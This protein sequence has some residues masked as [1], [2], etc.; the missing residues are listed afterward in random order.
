MP[1]LSFCIETHFMQFL[2]RISVGAKLGL[3]FAAVLLITGALGVLSIVQLGRV[4][5]TASDMADSWMPSM[6]AAQTASLEVARL[7]TREYRFLLTDEAQRPA[8]IEQLKSAAAAVELQLANYARLVQSDDERNQLTRTQEDWAAYLN[9]DRAMQDAMARGD[10]DLASE[11]LLKRGVPS[12]DALLASLNQLTKM[13]ADGAEA[14]NDLGDRIY[15]SSRWMVIGMTVV[16]VL[17]GAG[18]AF[19]ITRLITHPLADAVRL[20]EAVAQGDL[21]RSLRVVG[22]DEL[23]QLQGALLRMV[24]RLKSVVTQVRNGVDSVSSASSQI[25]T[26][27]HDLSA[28]TEQTAANLEETASSMEELTGT[29]G[30][31]ADTARQANQLASSAAEA[32]ARGG[33]VV[34]G[35]VQRMQ[36]ISD[37]SRKIADIIG[38]I[39]GIAFQTNILALNAAVEAARAGEQG[40]GFAVVASEVRSLAQRSAEAAKQIKGLIAKSVETVEA[41]STDVAQAGQVM[42]EIVTGVRRVTDLMAEIAAAASEQRDGIG[43]VNQAVANLDQMTQQN[44]ALVE[45]STAA[46]SSLQ[47]QAQRLA[48][49]VAVFNVGTPARV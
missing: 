47:E 37:S 40:R 6:R 16:A 2:H 24:E 9:S 23:A 19:V 46:S 36:E 42:D 27:N 41:G 13:N 28:R 15:A 44:A 10:K 38:V 4:S 43:Q 17:L 33:A 7:R 20:A 11:Q 1:D 5:D 8:V 18:L 25:A 49:V 30:Q 31:S 48:E 34:G 22:Q 21:T 12:Y 14:A 35:V 3:A 32:A 29:V 39:D 45:E 26:G